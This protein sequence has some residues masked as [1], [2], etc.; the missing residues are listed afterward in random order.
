MCRFGNLCLQENGQS[1]GERTRGLRRAEAQAR[2]H[3]VAARLPGGTSTRTLESG[4][5][6]LE[7][8]LWGYVVL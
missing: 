3:K 8:G 6:S 2:L 5:A 7:S 4:G 1:Q